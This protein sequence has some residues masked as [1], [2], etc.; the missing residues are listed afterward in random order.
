MR[1]AMSPKEERREGVGYGDE[2]EDREPTGCEKEGESTLR[3]CTKRVLHSQ[4]RAER[5]WVPVSS[6]RKARNDSNS[7][8][9]ARSN[10]T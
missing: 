3:E 1:A 9:V 8:G 5:Q 10:R 4:T 2:G 7:V 6:V